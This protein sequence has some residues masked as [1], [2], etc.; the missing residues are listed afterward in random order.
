MAPHQRP[1]GAAIIGCSAVTSNLCNSALRMVCVMH[2]HAD[3][4]PV[5][6]APADL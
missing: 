1:A 5:N 4:Q 2:L 3:K 6:H